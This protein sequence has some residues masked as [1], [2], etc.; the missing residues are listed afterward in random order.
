MWPH[1][2]LVFGSFITDFI[3][4]N[5]SIGNKMFFYIPQCLAL[6]LARSNIGNKIV[7]LTTGKVPAA[8]SQQVKSTVNISFC[9]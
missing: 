8:M 7:Y 5:T 9:F 3:P 6:L 2:L 4:E 1:D